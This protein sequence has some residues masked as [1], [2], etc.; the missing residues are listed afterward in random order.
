[1]REREPI[2]AQADIVVESDEGPQDVVVKRIVAALNERAADA[3][4]GA[5]R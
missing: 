2:Y 3:G 4:A 1:L 5:K